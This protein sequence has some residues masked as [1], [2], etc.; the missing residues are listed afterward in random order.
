VWKGL[1]YEVWQQPESA[2]ARILEHFPLGHG[3]QAGARA[4]CGQVIRLAGVAAAASGRLATAFRTPAT[5]VALSHGSYPADWQA[6]AGEPNILVPEGSG[7]V[8]ADVDVPA[9]ASYETWVGGSFRDRLELRIDGRLVGDARH[10]LNTSGQ[11]T[12]LGSVTL[13]AG[14]HRITLRYGG[15][16]LY[17]G[18]GGRPFP[19]GPLVLSRDGADLPVVYVQASG[20][21]ALCGKNLDWIEAVGS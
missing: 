8:E 15:P 4:P 14:A 17:P 11:Y 19:L 18:S 3:L 20:A 1:Y 9:T 10:R 13:R 7:T 16:D 12:P 2:Q 21:R 5:V 6:F